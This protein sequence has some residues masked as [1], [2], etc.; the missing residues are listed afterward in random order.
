MVEET[1]SGEPDQIY[2]EVGKFGRAH[3]VKGEVRVFT[4]EPDW[5]LFEPGATLYVEGGMGDRR[6]VTIEKWRIADKFVIAKFESIDDRNEAGKLSN[7]MLTVPEGELPDLDEAEYYHFDLEGREV[8]LRSG[9][10]EEEPRRVG[11][12]SGI[13][14]TGA[15]DV[16]VVEL[17]AGDELYV[18]MF[19]GAVEPIAPDDDVVYLRPLEEW[20]PEDTDI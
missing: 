1:E 9:G 12:V 19:E 16:L 20:A 17:D 6:A 4:E 18:P 5:A 8:Q 7:R 2:V 15:N 14:E 3:G 11:A 10:A 13:F